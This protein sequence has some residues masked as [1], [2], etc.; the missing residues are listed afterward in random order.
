LCCDPQTHNTSPPKCCQSPQCPCPYRSRSHS[1]P[2]S[3]TAGISPSA[4][5]RSA[6]EIAAFPSTEGNRK[7]VASDGKQAIYAAVLW[8]CGVKDE[9]AGCPKLKFSAFR[10]WGQFL[11][12]RESIPALSIV[13]RCSGFNVTHAALIHSSDIS[14]PKSLNTS[15]RF[16]VISLWSESEA[17]LYSLKGFIVGPGPVRRVNRPNGTGPEVPGSTVDRIPWIAPGGETST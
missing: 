15:C 16:F 3:P 6:P 10:C 4:V 14:K 9:E 11:S 5:A 17:I 1:F 7:C 2:E 8:T 13:M 12:V